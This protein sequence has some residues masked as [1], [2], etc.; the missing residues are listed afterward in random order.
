MSWIIFSWKHVHGSKGCKEK[1]QNNDSCAV[2]QIQV[3]IIFSYIQSLLFFLC[4]IL[5]SGDFFLII[6]IYFDFELQDKNIRNIFRWLLL[7]VFELLQ[8]LRWLRHLLGRDSIHRSVELRKSADQN[9]QR[10]HNFSDWDTT[11]WATSPE[12]CC[13]TCI[14]IMNSLDISI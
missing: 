11:F 1:I 3:K 7:I 13:K 12:M 5:R 10:T 8:T 9:I 2:F 6:I 14:N 4:Q